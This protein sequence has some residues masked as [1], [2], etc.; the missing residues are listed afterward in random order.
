M[1]F[2]ALRKRPQRTP[3]ALLPCKDTERRQPS[4]E[5]EAGLHQTRNIRHLDLRLPNLQSRE[6]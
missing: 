6:P 5:Q 4:M 3:L 2:S 1:R